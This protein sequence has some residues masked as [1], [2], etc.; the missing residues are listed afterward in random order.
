M[1]PVGYYTMIRTKD[2]KFDLRVHIVRYAVEHG[3]RA[4]AKAFQCSRNTVR[5]RARRFDAQ[6]PEGLKEKSRAPRSCPHKTSREAEAEVIRQRKRTPGFG[7]ARLKRE[8]GLKCGGSATARIIRQ[9]GLTARRKKKHRVKRDLRAVKAAYKPLTRFHMDVKY[10]ND[11]PNYWTQMIGLGLPKYQ[12]TVRCLKTGATFLTYGSEVSIT[13]AELT[14]R[15]LLEHLERYGIDLS[16]VVIQTDR[17]SE[18]EGN[19]VRGKEEGFTHTIE[20][21]FKAHHRVILRYNPNANADVESFHSHEE[22]EFFDIEHFRN[23][24]EFFEKVTIY[25]HYWNLGRKNSYKWWKSPL[26]ILREAAPGISPFALLLPPLDLDKGTY[27]EEDR[28]MKRRRRE[29]AR[30]ADSELKR[31][32][33]RSLSQTPQ[34]GHDVPVLTALRACAFR[35]A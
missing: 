24:E 31:A 2:Q 3:I 16:E 20:E 8:F 28:D 33:S 7:A 17:G 18:F 34:V 29:R 4:C 1:Y 19:V 27:L 11:I 23:R 13:Y 6:G 32:R 5:K 26:E 25:Q 9:N 14:V 10:L 35:S 12:Y 15:R 22:R 21:D 30:G